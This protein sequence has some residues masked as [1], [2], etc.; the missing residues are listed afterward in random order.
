M[1]HEFLSPSYLRFWPIAHTNDAH[2]MHS[3]VLST[4][5]L[6]FLYTTLFS[7]PQVQGDENSQD[8]KT[9]SG[10]QHITII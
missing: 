10:K 3:Y 8:M 1:V 6:V 5:K 7:Q 2:S 4:C 9:V